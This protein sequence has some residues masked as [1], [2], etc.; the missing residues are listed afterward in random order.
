MP[1]IAPEAS[2]P[3]D[4]RIDRSNSISS[5]SETIS[6]ATE[7]ERG[8][9]RPGPEISL[10]LAKD[11]HNIP[12]S[13]TQA[14]DWAAEHPNPEPRRKRWSLGGGNDGHG[15][16]LFSNLDASKKKH[17]FDGCEDIKPKDGFI[18]GWYRRLVDARHQSGAFSADRKD[19]R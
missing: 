13:D 19:S 7:I 18:G 3:M 2:D 17:M 5:M 10:D 14:R 12:S 1:E 16:P 8:P 15:A 4:P 11:L 6:F 9:E